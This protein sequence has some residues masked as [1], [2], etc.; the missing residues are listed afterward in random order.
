MLSSLSLL[1][2]TPPRP[3]LGVSTLTTSLLLTLHTWKLTAIPLSFLL[4]CIANDHDDEDEDDEEVQPGDL[5]G[6]TEGDDDED[7]DDDD[8]EEEGDDK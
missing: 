8:E 7:E 5:T 4:P 6:I 2:P 3:L 1:R